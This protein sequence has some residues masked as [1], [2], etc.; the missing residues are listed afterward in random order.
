M[1]ELLSHA[2]EAIGIIRRGTAAGRSYADIDTEVFATFPTITVETLVSAYRT[3]AKEIQEEANELE[4]FR[5]AKFG[6]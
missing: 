2:A 1:T 6:K 4:A 5:I 3:V